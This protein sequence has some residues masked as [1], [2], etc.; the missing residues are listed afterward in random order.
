MEEILISDRRISSWH[1][2]MKQNI[3]ELSG[4]FEGDIMEAEPQ[5][6]RRESQRNAVLDE[7]LRWPD[8]LV[9]Y[10]ISSEFGK[11]KN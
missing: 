2:K 1:P 5:P 3:W 6:E 9:P 8:A 11:Q 4:L 7:T 10:Y